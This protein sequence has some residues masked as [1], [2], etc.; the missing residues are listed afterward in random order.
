[1]TNESQYVLDGGC[2]QAL[3]YGQSE[4]VYGSQPTLVQPSMYPP[5]PH[6]MFFPPATTLGTADY[7]GAGVEED[8]E[9][10]EEEYNNTKTKADADKKKDEE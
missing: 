3:D 8:E 7:D 10:D 5:T 4:D 2:R 9:E 1:M 6:T